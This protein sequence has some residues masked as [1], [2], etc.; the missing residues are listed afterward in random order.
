M[1]PYEKF[2]VYLQRKQG[3]SYL[4]PSYKIPK[5]YKMHIQKYALFMLFLTTPVRGQGELDVEDVEDIFM[6]QLSLAEQGK[7]KGDLIKSILSHMVIDK[8]LYETSLSWTKADHGIEDGINYNQYQYPEGVSVLTCIDHIKKKYRRQRKLY[9]EDESVVWALDSIIKENL[10][11]L[12]KNDAF[13]LRIK[14][15]KLLGDYYT[16]WID[17][18]DYNYV[19]NSFYMKKLKPQ[20]QLVQEYL[21]DVQ[22]GDITI[23]SIWYPVPKMPM[24][25][26]LS[27]STVKIGYDEGLKV[28]NWLIQRLEQEELTNRDLEF[29]ANVVREASQHMTK[30]QYVQKQLP[31]MSEPLQ[32]AEMFTK[33]DE[34]NRHTRLFSEA[35]QTRIKEP[36]SFPFQQ[37]RPL[38]NKI[39][40]KYKEKLKNR[41]LTEE[42]PDLEK[43]L[44]REHEEEI[45]IIKLLLKHGAKTTTTDE[46]GHTVPYEDPHGWLKTAQLE[47]KEEAKQAQKATGERIG[48]RSSHKKGMFF[49]IASGASLLA[50]A[51]VRSLKKEAP[52]KPTKKDRKNAK[53][54]RKKKAK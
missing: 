48:N 49:F 22:N 39:F 23:G 11:K 40:E 24:P 33:K 31:H 29:I 46:D 28:L 41:T 50:Y 18:S 14:A 13:I 27:F 8:K 35:F 37:D 4:N 2:C 7:E 6:A 54:A 30:V 38:N 25:V 5:D 45:R 16:P 36:P 15:Q 43:I 53:K 52:T 9:P 21:K 42:D 20:L 47:L 34:F 32:N 1:T 17:K 26:P 12:R 44:A 3:K 10:T 51:V 19:K